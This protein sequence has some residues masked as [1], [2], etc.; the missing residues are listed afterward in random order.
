MLRDRQDVP[1]TRRIVDYYLFFGLAGITTLALGILVAAHLASGSDLGQSVLRQA[2]P[3]QIAG[4][5]PY[6]VVVPIAVLVAG[7]NVLRRSAE[8][9][10]DIETQLRRISLAPDDQ[11]RLNPVEHDTPAAAGWNRIVQR[12]S[13]AGTAD[14]E[15]RV[16]RAVSGLQERHSHNVLNALA[17]GVVIS[18]AAGKIRF[19]NCAAAALLGCRNADELLTRPLDEALGLDTAAGGEKVRRQFQNPADF[20]VVAELH[21]TADVADGVLRIARSPVPDSGGDNS[22][23]VWTLRDVTQTKLSEEMRTQFVCSATHELRTPLAN[24]KAYAETLSMDDG[25]DFEKQKEFFNIINTEATRLSRFVDDLLD[26]SR[27]E[28]GSLSLE[29]HETDL[30]RMVEEVLEKVRPQAEQKGLSFESALPPKLPKL[31]LDKDKVAA[32]LVN[33]LGNA[34]KYTPD[35]GAVALRVEN[36]DDEIRIH[37]E[38]SGIGIAEE[39][40]PKVFNKFFRSA[41]ERIQNITGSGLGLSFAQEVTRL[42]GGRIDLHSEVGR[43]S[44]FTLVLPAS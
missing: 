12:L 40:I 1:L 7:I 23:Y 36:A 20:C 33:L 17:D 30:Q 26:I 6:A 16:T 29:R 15:E 43:G 35:G 41:D 32:A 21:K 38:D 14:L 4:Y 11:W 8:P 25:I 42:H 39:E 24:I 19:A 9:S 18:D 10:R 3:L 28:A 31:N 22:A 13:A 37:V 34:V 44:R 27:M 5:L 2:P